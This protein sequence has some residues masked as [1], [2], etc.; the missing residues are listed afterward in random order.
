MLMLINLFYVL[1]VAIGSIAIMVLHS[2]RWNIE[3]H[4]VDYTLEGVAIKDSSTYMELYMLVAKQLMVDL[5]KNEVQIEYK[6]EESNV[7]MHI[8]NDMGV[9]VYVL[10]KKSA[11]DFNMYPICATIVKK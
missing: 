1:Y 2:G 5:A 3:N 9:R 7:P 6:V 8:H 10:L 11:D 4:Y